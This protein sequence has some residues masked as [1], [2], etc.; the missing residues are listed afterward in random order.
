VSFT[1]ISIHLHRGTPNGK[2]AGGVPVGSNRERLFFLLRALAQ[3]II[4]LLDPVLIN[5]TLPF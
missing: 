5:L 1:R 2:E 3:L 4:E